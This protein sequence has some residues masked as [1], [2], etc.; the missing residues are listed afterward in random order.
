M[1]FLM[2][3]LPGRILFLGLLGLLISDVNGQSLSAG[4]FQ[5]SAAAGTRGTSTEQANFY[6]ESVTRFDRSINLAYAQVAY[7]RSDRLSLWFRYADGY[8][9]GEYALGGIDRQQLSFYAGG[10]HRAGAYS[11]DVEYAYHNYQDSLYQDALMA[12]QSYELPGGFRPTLYAR[13]GIGKQAL[14]EWMVQ[15]G[16]VIPV[17]QQVGIEPVIIGTRTILDP[18]GSAMLG[19]RAHLGFFEKGSLKAAVSREINPLENPR[20]AFY[21]TGA[22]PFM[23]WH[24][25]NVTLQHNTLSHGRTTLFALGM[26]LGIGRDS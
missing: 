22:I 10:H 18:D 20:T 24:Q 23:Q 14:I 16:V 17:G 15:A 12:A 7:R 25:L 4:R 9:P 11:L 19:L 2:T 3:I 5:F 13:I 1:R 8:N 21:L 6:D 26:T